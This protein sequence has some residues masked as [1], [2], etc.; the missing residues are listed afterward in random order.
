MIRYFDLSD[1][2]FEKIVVAIGQR[3]FGVGLMGFAPGKDA[4]RDAKS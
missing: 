1:D 2:Q 4:G 3:L